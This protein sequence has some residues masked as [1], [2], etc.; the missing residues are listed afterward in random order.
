MR[1]GLT[2]SLLLLPA[3]AAQAAVPD[4]SFTVTVSE[5]VAV[6]G[7]PRLVLDV[8]GVT[9]YATYASGSGS[10]ALTF[11]Y[12]PQVGD[13]DLNGIA[14]TS[15]LDLNSG[16]IKDL[17][18][19]NL[20]PLSFTLPN[21][22]DIKIDYPSL[23][24]DFAN[25]RFLLNG[26]SYG[27]FTAMLTAAGGSFTRTTIG[28]Y[29]NA[30]GMMQTSPANT[31]R[32]DFDPATLQFKGLMIEGAR[33]N[34]L[35]Q[36]NNI[37]ASPWTTAGNAPTVAATTTAPDGGSVSLYNFGT[38]LALYQ[39]TSA[40]AGEVITHSLWMKANKAAT[41]G[42]R[43]P[44]TTASPANTASINLTT[45]WQ[46]FVL[47]AT[48]TQ[49]TTRLLIDNRLSSGY[50]VTGLQIAFFGGQIETGNSASSYI[51]T[52][53]AAVTRAADTLNIPSGGWSS[54]TNGTF[55]SS[56]VSSS[57]PSIVYDFASGSN[58]YVTAFVGA[59]NVWA[60]DVREANVAQVAM[61]NPW[62]TSDTEKVATA[63][64]ANNFAYVKEGGVVS[65]DT[66]G[67]VPSMTT[68]YIGRNR[69]SNA[70]LQGHLRSLFYYPLRLSDAQMQLITQ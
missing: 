52:T 45:S 3:L 19:N 14:I 63:Y 5:A 44:G 30:T 6:T 65:T 16:T 40:S 32:L 10:S 2:L 31:P 38:D 70:Y 66:A 4:L 60:Y 48:S 1:T 25:N 57:S 54:A 49:T 21:T 12:S 27:S 46:R 55:V 11:T 26:T 36:S 67:S 59:S 13:V 9:R 20:S 34:R 39:D 22:S 35:L 53:T 62:A 23:G 18:G 33:T 7:S 43:I 17:A 58:D 50:G 29:F 41:V 24:V 47:T 68:L 64:A 8:G 15:P 28:T 61:T 51:P 42:F 56:T 69:L 37:T